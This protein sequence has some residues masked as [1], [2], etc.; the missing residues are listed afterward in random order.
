MRF[1]AL[2]DKI[3][4]A[5]F[6]TE[7]LVLLTQSSTRVLRNL[8]Q[9]R[10]PT[11]PTSPT[12][13]STDRSQSVA[14]IRSRE[15]A[16]A[17]VEKDWHEEGMA[18]LMS[19]D[20]RRSEPN[21]LRN[22]SRR[23][24][25]VSSSYSMASSATDLHRS[26]TRKASFSR[27]RAALAPLPL[28]P[29]TLLPIVP[30]V[31]AANIQPAVPPLPSPVIKEPITASS[32]VDVPAETKP[33]YYGDSQARSKL[34]TFLASPEKFDEALEFGF[35]AADLYHDDDD[36]STSSAMTPRTP[37][38]TSFPMTHG[39]VDSGISIPLH[40]KKGSAN[41]RSLTPDLDGREMTLKLTLTRKDLR[42]PGAD[43]QLYSLQRTQVS[44]VDI[45]STS[46]PL[47]LGSL[48]ICDDH[49]GNHGAFAVREQPSKRGLKKLFSNIRKR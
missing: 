32:P 13:S 16:P 38:D 1:L 19:G 15:T 4:R 29:P 39:S 47:A 21:L 22:F 34:R 42:A 6:N 14:S 44:G 30:K 31:K 45:E 28:P 33:R 49:S 46:D 24:N 10:S 48:V 8:Q 27:R 36:D 2:P 7:E 18:T 40:T 20:F 35:P 26:S 12:W 3:K 41:L 5:H 17:G 37:I 25:S 11:S 43:Q 23:Q 9:A